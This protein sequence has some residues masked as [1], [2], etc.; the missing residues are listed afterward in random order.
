VATCILAALTGAAGLRARATLR[1]GEEGAVFVDVSAS[2]DTARAEPVRGSFD[3]AMPTRDDEASAAALAAAFIIHA[4]RGLVDGGEI[5]TEIA[6]ASGNPED[7]A[8][9]RA[10]VESGRWRTRAS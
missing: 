3:W 2:K 5:A 1:A 7:A 10:A 9:A 8:R 4:H 6:A